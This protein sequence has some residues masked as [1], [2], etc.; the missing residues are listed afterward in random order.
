MKSRDTI[1]VVGLGHVGLPTAVGFADLGLRVIGAD[2]DNVKADLIRGG[3]P[4]FYEPDLR[5][6]LTN[7]LSNGS[8]QVAESVKETI[9]KG[10][11]IIGCVGTP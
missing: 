4:P 6:I 11:V 1:G 7:T 5:E 9:A 3:T 10:D 8:F 2:D